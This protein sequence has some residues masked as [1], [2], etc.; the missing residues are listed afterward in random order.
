MPN[1]ELYNVRL[2]ILSPVHVGSGQE[3]DPFSYVI[4]DNKLLIIDPYKWIE[5]YSDKETLYQKMDSE[6]YIDLRNYIAKNFND[7]N[8]VLSTI[9]VKSAEVVRTYKKAV[10][11]K[12]SRKQALINFMT[13]N[14][15]TKIPYLPGSSIKGAIRTAIANSFVLSANIKSG[16]SY[17]YNKKIFGKPTDDPMKNLKVSDISLNRFGSVIFEAREHSP[18]DKKTPK[19]SYEAAVSFCQIDT[20]VVYPLKMSLNPFVLDSKTVDVKFLIE[21]LHRFYMPKFI[22]EYEKFYKDESYKDIRQAIAPLNMEALKLKTNEA[23]VRIGHFS[24]VECVTLDKVRSPK[25]RKGKDGKPLPWGKTRTLANGIYPFGWVKLEFSDFESVPR[26]KEQW[27]FSVEEI[28]G[29]IQK[30][31]KIINEKE[32]STAVKAAM[33]KEREIKIKEK[34]EK[35]RLLEAMTPEEREIAEIGDS[36]VLEGRVVEI[37][38]KIDKFSEE[39]KKKL[40]IALKQYWKTHGK[41]EKGSKKQRVKVQKVKGIL[42]K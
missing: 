16:D 41:W 26:D 19:D 33:E 40:A 42:D 11:D 14:E 10:Y 8:A 12:T 39:N 25:T 18:K 5:N 23:L 13:R 17:N 38:N 27:P 21:S 28:E 15:I 1:H 36:S 34:E 24:H 37:Y 7:D 4:R 29:Y 6:D 30:R 32:K 35:E 22:E 20:P 3:L 9:D 2:H 31:V